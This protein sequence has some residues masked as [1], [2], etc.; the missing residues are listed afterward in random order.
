M[1]D[2]L[3]GTYT[4][5]GFG[6][7][8]LGGETVTFSGTDQNGVVFSGT[9]YGGTLGIQSSAAIGPLDAQA[10]TGSFIFDGSIRRLVVGPQF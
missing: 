10:G 8:I 4:S 2:I 1:S 6:T 9:Y 7:T 3:T 5:A